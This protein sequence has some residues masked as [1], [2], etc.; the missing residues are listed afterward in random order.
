MTRWALVKRFKGVWDIAKTKH[1][2]WVL[3]ED[4]ENHDASQRALIE[5]QAKEIGGLRGGFDCLT[6]STRTSE[7]ASERR[8]SH[9]GY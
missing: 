9:A 2:A 4:H 8:S 1:G 3:F 7:A 6:R 5:Q